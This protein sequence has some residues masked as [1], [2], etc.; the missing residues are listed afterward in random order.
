[1]GKSVYSIVLTDEVVAAIDHLALINGTNR[2][3]LID[4]ILAEQVSVVTPERR[5]RDIL[6]NILHLM[7]ERFIRDQSA[8]NTALAVRS[9]LSY[10]Y[11]PTVRY[12]IE[13]LKQPEGDKI[14][15]L[16]ISF[17]TRS[18]G[19][20][21]LLADFFTLWI[22]AERELSGAA[23]SYSADSDKLIRTLTFPKGKQ[24]ISANELGELIS[25]Y[26]KTFDTALKQY[27]TYSS[28][29][30]RAAQ[31]VINTYKGA[32]VKGIGRI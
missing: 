24:S 10:K 16:K 23:A 21:S 27:F 26:I 31:A 22:N 9:S 2:S 29:P 4:R 30:A 15:V 18:E 6:D 14:G 5:V 17:R 25:D 1:M 11:K 19:F 13:L 8:A 32:L 3:S 28:E 20:I 7:D 12:S